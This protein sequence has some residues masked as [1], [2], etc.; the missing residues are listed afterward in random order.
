MKRLLEGRATSAPPWPGPL[1]DPS[2]VRR[3]PVRGSAARIPCALLRSGISDLG[4]ITWGLLRLHAKTEPIAASYLDIAD[5]LGMADLSDKAVQQRFGP[6][7]NELIVGGWLSRHRVDRRQHAY[8]ARTLPGSRAGSGLLRLTDLELLGKRLTVSHVVDFCRW[9][10]ECGNRGW[11]ADPRRVIAAR[12][13]MSER[14]F[15]R[16]TAE[17]VAV[18]L[19]ETVRR[20]G[21]T[22][23]TWL[24]EL[25]DESLR[26]SESLFTELRG[27]G[28]SFD[29][30]GAKRTSR[31]RKPRGDGNARPLVY[32]DDGQSQVPA[33]FQRLHDYLSSEP[34]STLVLTLAQLDEMVS[35]GLPL[36]GWCSREW[37]SNDPR[38]PQA[39]TWLL[40]SRLAD[41]NPSGGQVVFRRRVRSAPVLADLRK[42]RAARRRHAQHCL[43]TAHQDWQGV[44]RSC[45]VPHIVYLLHL[46]SEGL[47]KV[48]ITRAGTDRIRMLSAGRDAV[49]VD[50]VEVPNRFIAE[51]A[52]TNILETVEPWHELG[53][54]KHPA[55]GYTEMW[56][57]AGPSADLSAFVKAAT[58]STEQDTS[59]DDATDSAQ[60]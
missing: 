15:E 33:G 48:G 11:T 38:R 43:A 59:L 19:I 37:W 50:Q 47:F 55:G 49:I 51:V 46:P 31:P 44:R 5:A 2:V 56:S 25:L 18:G 29:L 28:S 13:L 17:L 26:S 20:P 7:I 23:L 24:R 60:R 10:I 40:T 36:R 52:E 8:C 4:V 1:P 27:Q 3:L 6:P 22:D 9:Q 16:R 32:S 34:A 57:D 41:A 12:W 21:Y 30:S 53:N 14:T 58:E 42:Q 35:G 54:L 45:W 39:R